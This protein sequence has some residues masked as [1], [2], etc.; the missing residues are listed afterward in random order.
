M[1]FVPYWTIAGVAYPLKYNAGQ[2]YLV[3]QNGVPFFIQ[4]DSPWYLTEALYNSNIDWYL[5]NRCAQGFNSII[6]DI[7]ATTDESG[8]SFGR[9]ANIYGQNPFTGTISGPYTNLLSWNVN[10]FT[11]VDWVIQRAAYYGICCFVYPMF[12]GGLTLDWYQDASQNSSNSI[13]QWGQFIGGRYASYSNIV[14]VAAGDLDEAGQPNCVWSIIANGILSMDPNH[15]ITAQTGSPNWGCSAKSYYTNSWCDL[16]D[17]YARS[18]AAGPN[19]TTYDFAKTNWLYTPIMPSFSR[20]PYYEYTTYLPGG[21]TGPGATGYDCRRYAWGSVTFG[22]CGH[23]YGN[24]NIWP[25]AAN[26]QTY[27]T[28][29]GASVSNVIKLMNTRPWWNCIPDYSKTVVTAGYGT[30]GQQAFVTAMREASGKTIIAYVPVGSMTPSFAMEKISGPAAIAW[31]YDPRSGAATAI[32]AYATIGTQTFTPPDTNDWVLVLDDAAQN[33]PP[34]GVN[35]NSLSIQAAGGGM[36]QLTVL[37]VPGQT[38]TIEFTTNLNSPW[39]T[40]GTG[41]PDNSGTFTVDVTAASS[42]CFYRSSH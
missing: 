14:Y 35:V 21:P 7:T 42:A 19:Y 33:Y 12:D 17:S 29:P 16:N 15:L 2:H 8:F 9:T 26:W 41:R 3:D 1:C 10:Y 37:G 23:F 5:S 18:A 22:E 34:P 31:W 27:L 32:G 4:G 11:N 25:F 36:L 38:Y 30:Y 39:Q 24:A 20:E 6:L 40:L 13:Y 28:S